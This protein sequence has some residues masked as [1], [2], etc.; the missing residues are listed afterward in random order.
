M[1]FATISGPYT[2]SALAFLNLSLITYINMLRA[3]KHTTQGMDQSK[4]S[5]NHV[6][7]PTLGN[8][9]FPIRRLTSGMISLVT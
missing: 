7:E 3:D 2:E 4:I 6:F 1:F 8:K 9:C 5:A